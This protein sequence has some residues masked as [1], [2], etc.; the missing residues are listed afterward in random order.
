MAYSLQVVTSW[1][2]VADVSVDTCITSGTCQVLALSEGDV[3]TI[4]VFIALR[5]TEVNDE[6]VVLVVLVTT[7]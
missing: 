2:L 7:N 5:Q 1:L 4:R 3:L 6:N